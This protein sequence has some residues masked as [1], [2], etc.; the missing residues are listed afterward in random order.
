MKRSKQMLISLP[1]LT[2]LILTLLLL[3]YIGFGEAKRTYPQF[4]I[5]KLS[6]QAEII[7]NALS[8]YL[9]A[10][11]PLNQFSGFTSLTEG[12]LISDKD[13]DNINIINPDSETIFYNF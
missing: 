3:A 1:I 7:K 10:G 4:Q 6:T 12:L 5:K 2:V 9:Q 8:S 13:I 11:L